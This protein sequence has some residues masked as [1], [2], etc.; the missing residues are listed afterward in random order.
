MNFFSDVVDSFDFLE[1]PMQAA[2]YTWWNKRKGTQYVGSKL[3]RA[4]TNPAFRLLYGVGSI[5]VIPTYTSD[6]HA[7]IMSFS[8]TQH[9]AGQRCHRIAQFE[10]W[11]LGQDECIRHI[12]ERW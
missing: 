7:L 11:W 4:F 8:V 1:V 5:E 2:L 9:A 3:D 12:K 6:H 10:P